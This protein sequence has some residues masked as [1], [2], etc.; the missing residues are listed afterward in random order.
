VIDKLSSS[1]AK[2][3]KAANKALAKEIAEAEDR[4]AIKELI[5][6]LNHK[7]RNIQSDSIEVLYETGYV[8]PALIADEHNSFLGLL[9]DG[10]N[11]LVWGAMIALSSIAELV[12]ELIFEALP[13][14][15]KTVDKGTVIT[16]DAGMKVYAYLGTVGSQRAKVIPLLFDELKKCPAKQLGQ[17]AEKASLAID[18]QSREAFLG[19]LNSRLK[20]L[21]KESQIRRI[22]KVIKKME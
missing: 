8:K 1:T 22:K 9:D 11:R 15:K 18:K 19:I 16:K 7:D 5:E 12:P 4:K 17:Y 2:R 10:N 21:D 14:I 3:G 13:R 20:S 6:L